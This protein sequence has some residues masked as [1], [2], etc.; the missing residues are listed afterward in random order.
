MAGLTAWWLRWKPLLGSNSSSTTQKLWSSNSHPSPLK[1][2][3]NLYH[4]NWGLKLPWLHRT[5]CLCFLPALMRI[6]GGDY[7]KPQPVPAQKPFSKWWLL[8]LFQGVILLAL[9]MTVKPRKI[10]HSPCI[11]QTYKSPPKRDVTK[12]RTVRDSVPGLCSFLLHSVSKFLWTSQ[13]ST[14]SSSLPLSLKFSIRCILLL[15]W[16][17]L[18]PVVTDSTSKREKQT[19]LVGFGKVSGCIFY[20]FLFFILFFLRKKK[21]FCS[22]SG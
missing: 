9:L 13:A 21:S 8:R 1:Q 5:D 16:W 18:L 2:I 17:L 4:V 19:V 15:N 22:V 12:Q 14:L 11:W 6:K 20:S 3:S 7:I 10:L